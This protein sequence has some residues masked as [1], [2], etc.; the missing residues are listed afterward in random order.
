[1][2]SFSYKQLLIDTHIILWALESTRKLG[3][4]A[5]SVISDAEQAYVSVVS[6]W[7]LATKYKAGKLPYTSQEIQAAIEEMGMQILVLEQQHIAQFEKVVL[8]HKDPFDSLL[9]AQSLSED[10]SF[11]TAD[12]A[13]LSSKY[14]SLIDARI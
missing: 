14:N 6:L 5:T 3:P 2:A 10:L 12:Q 11:V 1:M 4:Q 9:I 13:I 8:P 7:E